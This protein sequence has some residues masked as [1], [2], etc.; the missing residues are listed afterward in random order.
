MKVLVLFESEKETYSFSPLMNELKESFDAELRV[1]SV[2]DDLRKV[3]NMLHGHGA[4]IIIAGSGLAGA[5]AGIVSALTKV[6][7]FGLP[8]E[9]NFGGLD[10]LLSMIQLPLGT[11]V[12]TTG[13]GRHNAILQFLKGMRNKK[14]NSNNINLIVDT[15]VM[16]YEYITHEI[17]RTRYLCEDKG[18]TL[19][20]SES[21]DENS[22]NI[23][24]VTEEDLIHADQLC[25]HVPIL[26]NTT[27]DKPT[28]AIMVFEWIEKGG[29]WLGVNNT[30]NAVL[31]F[32]RLRAAF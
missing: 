2:Y 13:P 28:E 31:S 21:V 1:I 12:M 14:I 11:P 7:V 24:L 17:N 15:G 25:L 8:V 10:A 19:S 3:E 20:V 32:L 29:I 9:T 22:F 26:E 16:N 18:L 30:R 5:N 27:R 23:S 6:P 4:D